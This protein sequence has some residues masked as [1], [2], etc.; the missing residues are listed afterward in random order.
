MRTGR[1]KSP[2][3]VHHEVH[4]GR[5][6]QRRPPG[7]VEMVADQHDIAHG[8]VRAQ[9]SGGVG[10]EEYPRPERGRHM[11]RVDHR[12]DAG[13]LVQMR[14][15]C[16]RQE[17]NAVDEATRDRSVVSRGRG[18]EEPGQVRDGDRHRGTRISESS[19]D[20]G[21]ARAQ[22]QGHLVV[23]TPARAGDRVGGREG[24]RGGGE[25]CGHDV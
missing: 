15:A 7:Q 20:P 4:E 5:A 10:Q 12:V 25:Q 9:T 22:D 23:V 1:T 16:H 13:A 2:A 14:A 6:G 8:H 11:D 3:V 19:H 18:R 24:D 21:P 17:G